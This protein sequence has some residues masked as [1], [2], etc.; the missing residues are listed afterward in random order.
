MKIRFLQII[1]LCA[2]VFAGLS[3]V[4]IA[5]GC[6]A[7]PARMV[8]KD[9]EVVNMHLRTV[10]LNESTGGIDPRPLWTSDISNAAFTE[11]LSRA[12]A[13]SG[14]FQ[15]V[16]KG[17]GVDAEGGADYI[18]DV[19]ILH[20]DRPWHGANITIGMETTWQLTDARTLTPVWIN[21]FKTT[22]RTPWGKSVF[23]GER[24]E[25]AHEAAV[26]TNIKEGIRR[27]SLLNL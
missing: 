9:F 7:K 14:V 2:L 6:A 17:G 8:P 21:T 10:S 3:T 22:H 11:A 18:L 24:I 25:Q 13:E 16:I 19:A 26:R 15:T 4:L 12:L 27:L 23:D 1:M 20:Y 5:S